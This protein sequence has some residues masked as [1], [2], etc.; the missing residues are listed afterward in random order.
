MC[1]CPISL[2]KYTLGN[3]VNKTTAKSKKL[4]MERIFFDMNMA[5]V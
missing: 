2:C 1:V 4:N 3:A 5:N